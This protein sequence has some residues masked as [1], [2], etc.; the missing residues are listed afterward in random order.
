[1]GKTWAQSA[2]VFN[3]GGLLARGSTLEIVL[4]IWA[5]FVDAQVAGLTKVAFYIMVQWSFDI[6]FAGT[7]PHK[8]HNGVP[9][10]KDSKEWRRAGTPLV[11]SDLADCFF[12]VLWRIKGDLEFHHKDPG[13]RHGSLYVQ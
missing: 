1:M 9:Y 11:G 8:D 6:L 5:C 4:L 2:D 12:C 7:W 3:W 10:P 13:P